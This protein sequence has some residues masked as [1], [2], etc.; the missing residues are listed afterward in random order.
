MQE[1]I[2][3][4]SELIVPR[5]GDD[6]LKINDR[7]YVACPSE[8]IE[9]TLAAFGH[10]EIASRKVTISGAG[11]IGIMIGKMINNISPETSLTFIELDKEIAKNAAEQLEF[12]SIIS[13]DTLDPE[14]IK[15]ARVA[16]GCSYIASTNHDE[17][18]SFI[19]SKR[20]EQR[21]LL[22]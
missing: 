11:N 14:I 9:R 13:G 12:A 21:I 1:D 2:I 20:S 22:H 7:I 17:V 10:S 5:S 15:E 19:I 6:E 4:G 8:Q 3:R 16:N 18:L